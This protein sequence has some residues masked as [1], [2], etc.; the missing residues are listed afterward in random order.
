MFNFQ[1]LEHA[2]VVVY[3]TQQMTVAI[4][5]E[6]GVNLV[7]LLYALYLRDFRVG[8][9]H[10]WL[11]RHDVAYGVVEELRLPSLCGAAYVAI[12]DESHDAAFLHGHAQS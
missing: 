4:Y 7:S 5:D 3:D 6:Q 8:A 9:Y 1:W 11:S 12:G 10:L 2:R